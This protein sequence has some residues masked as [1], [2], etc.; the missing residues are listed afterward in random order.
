MTGEGRLP[1]D[2]GATS[3][4]P[5]KV[6]RCSLS[7]SSIC[8]LQLSPLPSGDKRLFH[9]GMA[10]GISFLSAMGQRKSQFVT[11]LFIAGHDGQSV[12]L[13]ARQ[14]VARFEQQHVEPRRAGGALLRL[15][16]GATAAAGQ[17]AE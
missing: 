16:H 6:R 3:A 7:T 10:E 2:T 5:S 11:H 8:V 1:G 13:G 14:H 9:E 17:R 15:E 4:K 12:H